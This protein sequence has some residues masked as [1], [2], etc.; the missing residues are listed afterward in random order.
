MSP[1]LAPMG[2][3]RLTLDLTG[4]PSTEAS[5]R[6]HDELTA[7]I[8][9]SD[10]SARFAAFAVFQ[11]IDVAAAAFEIER[12]LV[13]MRLLWALADNCSNGKH[14]DAAGYDFLWGRAS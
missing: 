7:A 14:I 13:H 3:L 6:G 9:G 5:Q 10:Q 11:V 1:K 4:R 8:T 12:C 2:R